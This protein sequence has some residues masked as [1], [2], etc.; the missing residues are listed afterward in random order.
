MCHDPQ[1]VKQLQDDLEYFTELAKAGDDSA[2]RAAEQTALQLQS[3][4]VRLTTTAPSRQ[5]ASEQT[6][7]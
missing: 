4:G 2:G 3:L 1:Y 5:Y 6:G 7:G